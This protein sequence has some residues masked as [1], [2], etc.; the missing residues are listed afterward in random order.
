MKTITVL[1]GGIAGISAGYHAIKAGVEADVYE[2]SSTVGGLVSNYMIDGFRFDNAVH[3]SFSKDQYVNDL[4]SRTPYIGH[5][6]DAYC[7]DQGLWLKHPVQNNLYPLP[8]E[9]K[10]SLIESFVERPNISPVNYKEWLLSQYGEEISKRYPLAYTRKYWGMDA[11]ALSLTWIGNRMRRAELKEILAGALEKKEENHY[12]ANEMRYPQNGGYKAFIQP[13]LDGVNVETNCKAVVIDPLLKAV[14]FE[15]G[16]TRNYEHLV[17]TIPLPALVPMIK[18]AP[19]AVLQAAESLLYT[20]VDLISIGFSR[21]DIPPYLW[22][23]LY[24][25][26]HLAA[27]GYSPSWKS[28]SNAPDGCSSLLKMSKNVN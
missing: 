24:G 1:G 25:D 3:L 17:S 22:F 12:Y 18:D 20:R 15:N 16:E 28:P 10:T 14:S 6:P 8:T 9:L 11:E 21:K 4:F 13:M 2:A 27:R 7:N 23:Y 19:K 5:K 26:E